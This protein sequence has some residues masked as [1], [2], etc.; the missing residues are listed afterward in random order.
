MQCSVLF[1][2]IPP[3]TE[4]KIL[5][6]FLKSSF[7]EPICK[8]Q[9]NLP[10]ELKYIDGLNKFSFPEPMSQFQVNLTKDILWV[11]AIQLSFKKTPFP[12]EDIIGKTNI[13]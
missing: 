8:F 1:W 5:D 12:R 7:R 2:S 10:K 3:Y 6:P 9:V 11:I 13:H 4:N